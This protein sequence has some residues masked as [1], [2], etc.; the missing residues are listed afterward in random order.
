MDASHHIDF[1]TLRKVLSVLRE[2]IEF[3]RAQ[4]VGAALKAHLR[5]AVIQSFEFSYELSMKLLR[6]SLMERA[7]AADSV[8]DL[9]FNDLMRLAADAGLVADPLS[10]RRWRELRNSTS[11]G[12]DERRAEEVAVGAQAFL[13]EALELLT[14]LEAAQNA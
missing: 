9:S 12:Y 8:T 14:C 1:S 13:P 11:H 10:W 3:W 6:R 4:P 5:S 2:A 7:I